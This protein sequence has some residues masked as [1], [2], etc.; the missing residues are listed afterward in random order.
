[1]NRPDRWRGFTLIELLV[2][3][4]IIAILIG[5]LL[6]AVQKVREAAARMK[7]QNNLKQLGLAMHNLES[8]TGSFPPGYVTFS[9]SYT[10]APNN[11]NSDGS[12]RGSYPNFPAFVVTGSQGGGIVTRAEVFGPAWVMHVNSYMEQTTLDQRVQQGVASDDLNESCPWDNLDGLPQRRPDIDTQSYIRKFMQCPS[13][14]QSEIHYN[15]LNLENLYKGNYVACFGG[16]FMRDATPRGNSQL[17]GVFK[18]VTDVKKF[19]YGDRF[20]AGKGTRITGIG[21]GTSN[22]VMLSELLA[23]HV[24]DGRTS[25]TSS[26]MNRDVRGAMLCPMMGGNSFS[27]AFPPNSRGTDITQGCPPSGDLAAKPAGDPMFCTLDR[28]LD[29]TTGGQWAVAAR[30]KHTG[31]VNAVLADGSVRFIREGISAQQWS[32][33]CTANGGEVVNID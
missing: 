19:P 33:L 9:E 15:D 27:G 18:A 16:G 23:N 12:V 29:P 11:Q 3:I 32:A 5:L 28:N 4:A 7:C 26:A 13:A 2:V 21:D 22:T 10:S 24:P 30:S 25:S 1:M 8:T 20:A 31:G 14:E 17:A 6:P